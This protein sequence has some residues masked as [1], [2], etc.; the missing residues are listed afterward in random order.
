MKDETEKP[1]SPEASKVELTDL[2]EN[3]LAASLASDFMLHQ[4]PEIVEIQP[5]KKVSLFLTLVKEKLVVVSFSQRFH[6][7]HRRAAQS[8]TVSFVYD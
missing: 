6:P 3:E 7:I 5:G 8:I 2:L 1:K 4:S